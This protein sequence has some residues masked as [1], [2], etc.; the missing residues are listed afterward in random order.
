MGSTLW[1]FDYDGVIADSLESFSAGFL[2]ACRAAGLR[3]LATREAFLDLFDT[4]LFDG[5]RAAGLGEE[6]TAPFLSLMAQEL[7]ARA[8]T[9][10]LFPRMADT[11]NRLRRRGPVAIVTSN[12]ASIVEECLGRHGV[13]QLK[14]ILGAEADT[15]KLRKLQRLRQEY[16][17]ARR[18]FVSD[19]A[20]DIREGRAAGVTTVAVTWGW[21]DRAR[22]LAA[23]PDHVA[24]APADLEALAVAEA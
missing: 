8:R 24:D 2:A 15:S 14:A 10:R 6:Q 16:P 21:H 5:L 9:V 1:I 19:T 18:L 12:L 13:G 4:N 3:R 22:L 23:V 17:D 11:L 7:T 20:G